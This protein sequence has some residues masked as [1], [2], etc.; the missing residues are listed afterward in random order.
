MTTRLDSVDGHARRGDARYLFDK[1]AKRTN[2]AE[3]VGLLDKLP[4]YINNGY[5]TTSTLLVTLDNTNL[6]TVLPQEE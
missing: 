6:Y 4:R 1:Y 2:I 3:G 5:L